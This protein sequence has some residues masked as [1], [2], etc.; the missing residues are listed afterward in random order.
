MKEIASPPV[1]VLEPFTYKENFE[2]GEL[3]AWAS[4]P[5]WQDTAFDPNFGPGA[6][7]PGDPNISI[8]QKVTPYTNVDNYAGAQKK[9][10]MYLI[11]DSTISLRYYLKTNLPVEFFK[12]RL[13]AG[14]DGK[15]DY[16]ISDPPTNRWEWITVSYTDFIRE[17]PHLA[18]KDRIKVN[19]L[20]VFSKFPDADPAM[21]IY[22]GL[23]DIV[24][25]GAR[26]M[27]FRFEEPCV[28]KLTEWKPYIPKNHYRLNEMFFLKGSWPLNATR[29]TLAISSF[30]D[31]SKNVYEADLSNKG[32]EWSIQFN[33]SFPEGLY[34]ATLIAYSDKEIISDTEFTLYVEPKN[35]GGK[36][37]R[38]W[39]DSVK[40]KRIKERLQLERFKEVRENILTSAKNARDKTQVDTIVFETDQFH[41]VLGAGNSIVSVYSWFERIGAWRESLYNNALAY[42]LLDVK[43]AGEYC[44]K[45][46]VK[47][48]KLP[49]WL[50][51]WFI[52]RGRHI[53][54]AVGELG[55]DVALAYDIVY[56]LMD[57][58]ERKIVRK[59][60]MN[61][62][63]IGCHKG[64]VE[65][66]LVTC[67]TSNW[68]AHITGGSL[69]CQAAMYGD[70]KDVEQTEPYFTGAVLKDY[71]L[72][73]KVIDRDGAYCEG[74]F[75]YN[76]S[77]MS[78]SKSLTA[79]ENVF[80]IDM[81]DKLHRS[82]QDIIWTGV[83]KNKKYFYF[84][85]YYG[86]TGGDLKPLTSWAWL[87]AKYKDPLLGWL[88]HFLKEGETLEDVLYEVE[89]V[90]R[91][92]PFDENPVKVFRDV[93]TVVFKSGWEPDD[94]I[95]VMR[96]GAFYNHEQLD[97]G[98][99]WLSDHG[100]RFIEER[101]GSHY[102]DDPLYQ[103]WYTQP[104]AHS[105][106]LI[107]HNHQ[108]QRVGDS[109][110]FAEGFHDH[111]FIHHFL[112][113]E[114]AAFSSGDIGRL[115][116]GK[117]KSIRR[118]VLYLKPRTILMLNTVEPKERNVDVTLLYQTLH[119]KDIAANENV[120]TISKNG[121]N[122]YIKHMYPEH[123]EVK[124]VETPHYLN[125][126]QKEKPLVKEGMLT[127]TA[128]TSGAPL[129]M[130]ELLTTTS[131]EK[132]DFTTEAGDGYISGSADGTPFAFSTRLY[133]VYEAG[134]FKTDALA[135]TWSNGH[136]FAALCTS[137][138]KD[139][140]L[141][142]QSDE[143][144]TCEI[145]Q[146]GIKY[147]LAQESEVLFGVPSKPS[148]ITVNNS[149]TAFNYDTERNTIVVK[150]PAGEGLVSF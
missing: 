134:G 111:A 146:K 28:Y 148:G 69:M 55:M 105:T 94:F 150:L 1:Y 83:I 17:N 11:H 45:L 147:Y 73:Q 70:G 15:V 113:G 76:F 142:L 9:L 42:S 46:L 79:V 72:I 64:Y 14:P 67:N 117:V 89:D 58:N 12:V 115:Y 62:I 114:K 78:W 122:L 138:E 63:V 149:P 25:K 7:V 118:N 93:G 107:D 65:N 5:L 38:I 119:L 91:K 71:S 139:G 86:D 120:S 112:N 96:S 56:D 3:G 144:V 141:L 81:S 102:Y 85:D 21:N 35:V 53:Y 137:L 106:I 97:Q 19:A 10:D 110:V 126:F 87:L 124:S 136:L 103:P 32:D 104:I 125:T 47:I 44:K 74:Y 13:A 123:K 26:A 20:A 6:I 24:F 51:P 90:P 50:H 99:F 133:S 54:Y 52:K 61:N 127:V 39:F 140:K 128:Q 116:L 18:G 22:L 4:Y 66:D 131:G 57:E 27:D 48:S 37:P 33:I 84:G 75:Y 30:T 8:V 23:D 132:P 143:P 16:T 95:F 129:V 135:I 145:S 121:N 109:L 68:V 2:T 29:V 88:Y 101:Y 98:T 41:P 49:Y 34:L 36:H 77:M 31:R 40:K 130:A 92:D 80:R 82:Y 108:S 100:R 60:M 43:E 59:A